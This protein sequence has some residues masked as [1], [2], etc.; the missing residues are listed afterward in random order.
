MALDASLIVIAHG[1]L[2]PSL[3]H[4]ADAMVAVFLGLSGDGVPM[5]PLARGKSVIRE[6]VNPQ[7]WTPLS[8]NHSV[9]CGGT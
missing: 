3:Q 6:N 4:H 5:H 9:A 7:P 1:N 8:V 2:P